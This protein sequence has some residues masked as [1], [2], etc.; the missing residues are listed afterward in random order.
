MKLIKPKKLQQGDTIGFLAVSGVINDQDGMLFA[1]KILEEKGYKIKISDTC[2][3]QKD[4]LC[5]GDEERA[6]ALNSFFAD[7]EIKAIICVRGGYGTIRILDKLDYKLIKKHPKIFCGFSDI[8]AILWQL[9][10]NCGLVTF[11]GA[12]AISTF[13]EDGINQKSFWEN[14]SGNLKTIK[15]QNHI[16]YNGGVAK[17]R[18]IGGNLC[19]IATLCGSDFFVNDDFILLLEDVDE[20][21]YTIDRMFS[22]LLNTK[23]FSKHLKGIALGEFTNSDNREYFDHF[24]KETAQ[25]L[26]IPVCGDFKISHDDEHLVTP[27]GI[28]A[29]FDATNGKIDFLENYFSD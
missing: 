2:F 1:K 15:T 11:H 5:A 26:N 10:R 4:Y 3:S 9:F 14:M 20:P 23:G 24:W 17:G 19:T 13:K 25:K 8:S 6:N 21:A 16:T 28:M 18:F 22:Q 12:H 7:D 27:Y 29:E